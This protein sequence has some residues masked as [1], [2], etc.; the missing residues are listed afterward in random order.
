MLL[1]CQLSTWLYFLLVR[2]H[3]KCIHAHQFIRLIKHSRT[4]IRT[5][6]YDS[7]THTDG[8]CYWSHAYHEGF[9]DWI[10]AITHTHTLGYTQL[11]HFEFQNSR[12]RVHFRMMM[13]FSVYKTVSVE[14]SNPYK[15]HTFSFNSRNLIYSWPYIRTTWYF[16]PI[17][18][19]VLSTDLLWFVLFIWQWPVRMNIWVLNFYLWCSYDFDSKLLV[20]FP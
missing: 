18:Y 13:N 2:F 12:F 20:R 15:I 19:H 4:H 3:A 17:R 1:A 6:K 16:I 8:P 7:Y 11:E 10:S 9:R 5:Y 14:I